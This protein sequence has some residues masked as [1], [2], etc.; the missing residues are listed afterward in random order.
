M[1]PY[2]PGEQPAAGARVIKLNTNENPYPPSPRVAEAIAAELA[3]DGAAGAPGARLRLYSDPAATTLRAVAAEQAGLPIECVLHGNG[4]DELLA[5]LVRSCVGEGDAVAYPHPTYVLYETLARAQGARLAVYDSP[6]DFALPAA[7]FGT[8]AKLVFVASPNSPSGIRYANEQLARLARGLP[9]ALVVID[10]AYA[11]F[12]DGDALAL[13]GT[14]PNLVVLRTLSKSHSLAGMRVGLLYGPAEILQ[15]VAKVKDS[16]NL[17]RLAIVAGTA[18]L[19]DSAWTAG[20]VGRV[21]AERERLSRGLIA[22]GLEVLP[23]EANFVFARFP[24][25][26]AAAAAYRFLRE[27]GILVRYFPTRLLDDGLRITVGTEPEVDAVLAAL[28]GRPAEP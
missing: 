2:V 18:S 3:A 10:E 26:G 27:Q 12:A 21:R 24:S 17:D 25:A 23:S 4:S 19:S 16:Y 13:V 20:N 11:P 5:M 22:L 28:R 7:L 15:G 9:E 14:L 1:R 8:E 6:R